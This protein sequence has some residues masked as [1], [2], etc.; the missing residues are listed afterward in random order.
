MSYWV[1]ERHIEGHSL[2]FYA[3]TPGPGYSCGWVM[4][5]HEARK[6]PTKEEATPYLAYVAA[7]WRAKG[8]RLASVEHEDV[9][10]PSMDSE[11]A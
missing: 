5:I 6:F 8:E 1:I 4:N 11:A 2:P 7:L 9:K 3:D 10:M